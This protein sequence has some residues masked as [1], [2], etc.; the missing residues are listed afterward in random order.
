ML[1][2]AALTYAIPKWYEFVIYGESERWSK[3]DWEAAGKPSAVPRIGP[4]EQVWPLPSAL[5]PP[6]LIEQALTA[7]HDARHALGRDDVQI[8]AED[9]EGHGKR[10][11]PCLW[12]ALFDYYCTKKAAE[13]HL[14]AVVMEARHNAHGFPLVIDI[15]GK[16]AGDAG[17]SRPALLAELRRIVDVIQVWIA[18]LGQL[19]LSLFLLLP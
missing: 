8:V 17:R 9:V 2:A 4:L 18:V 12:R 5:G 10:Y 6:L 19:L 11:A 15:D 3:R 16:N 13:R 14:Y 1:A 7:M